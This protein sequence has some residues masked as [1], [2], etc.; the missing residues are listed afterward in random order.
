M[1]LDIGS[2]RRDNLIVLDGQ[3]KDGNVTGKF[4]DEDFKVSSLTASGTSCVAVA[5]GEDTIGVR[6]SKNP[7][8]P[9]L[10]FN[11][12]EWQ[13]FLSGVKLGEFELQ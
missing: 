9:V 13:A 8:G 4:S 12:K 11:S 5:I 3:Q 2:H 6:D 7:D 10:L 1:H